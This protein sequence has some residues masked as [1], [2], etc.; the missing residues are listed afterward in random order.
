MFEN[1][2]FNFLLNQI[3][4][5]QNGQDTFLTFFRKNI[6]FLLLSISKWR[7]A[8]VAKDRK[9]LKDISKKVLALLP[10]QFLIF[11]IYILLERA[12]YE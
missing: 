10:C 4:H 7:K 9:F 6:F 11:Q 12:E 5:L 2:H 8:I 1:L 3:L